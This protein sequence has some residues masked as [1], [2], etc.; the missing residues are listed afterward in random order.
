[1]EGPL[2]HDP[3]TATI[4]LTL[5]WH[6]VGEEIADLKIVN[7]QINKRMKPCL[8]HKASGGWR[9]VIDLK[10]LNYHTTIL[11]FACTL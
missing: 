5:P 1:M 4:N 9:P 7:G 8:V 10:Q 6:S 11:T 2:Y 3:S